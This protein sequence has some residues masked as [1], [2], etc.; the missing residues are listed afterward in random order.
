MY[1][2]REGFRFGQGKEGPQDDNEIYLGPTLT[3]CM[4]RDAA[5]HGCRTTTQK[6]KKERKENPRET[7]IAG[8]EGGDRG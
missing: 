5:R 1:V 2:V 3:G 6:R 4:R 7:E 8:R